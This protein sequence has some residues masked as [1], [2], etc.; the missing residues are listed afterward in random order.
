M[1]PGQRTRKSSLEY[2]VS[3]SQLKTLYAA[4]MHRANLLP[5][6][7]RDRTVRDIDSLFHNWES[8][9]NPSLLESIYSQAQSKLTILEMSSP[10]VPPAPTDAGKKTYIVQQGEVREGTG[11]EKTKVDFSNWY[12]GNVDPADLKRHKELLERQHFGGPFWENRTRNP[13]ILEEIPTTYPNVKP[14]ARP[15]ESLRSEKESAFEEVKR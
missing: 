2:M 3:P 5:T 12:A 4:L 6:R 8:L 1:T 9:S 14:E 15:P 7:V 10:D 11:S 13:S